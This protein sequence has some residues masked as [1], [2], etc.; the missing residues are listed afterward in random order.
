MA[1]V[2]WKANSV[3]VTSDP[4]YDYGLSLTAD[5]EGWLTED[6]KKVGRTSVTFSEILNDLSER[7]N[8]MNKPKIKRVLF[9]APATIIFWEDGSKTVVKAQNG[10]WYDPEKGFVL[11]YLKK[12]LGNDNTF[13]KEINKW[14]WEK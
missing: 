8:G 4:L 2:Y 12:L 11:A 13:N 9:N 3:N 5:L 6:F 1:L 7:L 14:V 10:D